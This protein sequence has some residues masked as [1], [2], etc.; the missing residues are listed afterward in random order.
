MVAGI[1]AR[2]VFSRG[3]RRAAFRTAM[4]IPQ[5]M[6]YS[7]RLRRM[8]GPTAAGIRIGF[9]TA[10]V[11]RTA[12]RAQSYA[13]KISGNDRNRSIDGSRRRRSASL[14]YIYKY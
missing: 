9:A 3:I 1:L 6:S 12:Q 10:A 7:S 2:A 13:A 4:K 11:V 8:A 14:E 5:A